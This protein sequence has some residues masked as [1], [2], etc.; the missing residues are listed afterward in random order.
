MRAVIKTRTVRN[1]YV[2]PC[3]LLLLNIGVGLV[4]YKAGM[5]SSPLL[6]VAAIMGMVLFGGSL[7]GFV[8][9][10][11][12][13]RVIGFLHQRSRR[14][15]LWVEV[16]FLCLLGLLVYWLYY[17][18]YILGPKSILPADWRNPR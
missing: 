10:P 7:V 9:E 3:C 11:A 16:G 1:F 4:S 5:I 13:T 6:R 14:S 2:L 17:R 15:G 8:L 12:I 18:M